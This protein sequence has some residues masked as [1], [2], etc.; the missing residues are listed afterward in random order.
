MKIYLSIPSIRVYNDADGTWSE[1]SRKVWSFDI[2]DQKRDIVT[3]NVLNAINA[4]LKAAGGEAVQF[5][6]DVSD[7]IEATL[8]LAGAQFNPFDDVCLL[9]GNVFEDHY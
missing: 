3:M 4:A 6:R 2:G 7:D 5:R 9:K 1:V 8:F